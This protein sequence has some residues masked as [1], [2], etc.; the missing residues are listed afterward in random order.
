M[1]PPVS[2]TGDPDARWF[3]ERARDSSYAAY[4]AKESAVR[5]LLTLPA[6]LQVFFLQE[7]VSWKRTEGVSARW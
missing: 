5:A 3:M 6:F 2:H 7:V 4:R 1:F